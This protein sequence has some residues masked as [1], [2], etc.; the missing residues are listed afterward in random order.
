MPPGFHPVT[1]WE[2]VGGLPSSDSPPVGPMQA[3]EAGSLHRS[4]GS[5][6]GT[7]PFPHEPQPSLS[8]ARWHPVRHQIISMYVLTAAMSRSLDTVM[9]R[10][11]DSFLLT[12]LRSLQ[13]GR[14]S[15]TCALAS[16]GNGSRVSCCRTRPTLAS[17]WLP[18]PLASCPQRAAPNALVL[19]RP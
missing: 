4:H 18:P 14:A 8:L 16:C 1:A 15:R 2:G 5:N 7:C 12:W 17:R 11:E 9:E 3:H 13:V 10:I 19:P 6:S